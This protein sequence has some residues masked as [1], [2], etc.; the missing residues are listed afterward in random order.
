VVVDL[1]STY[2]RKWAPYGERV[3]ASPTT[4]I[5]RLVHP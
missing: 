2:T 5:L 4:V 3:D 1:A